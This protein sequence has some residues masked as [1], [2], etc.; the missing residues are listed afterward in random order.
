[1]EGAI[2]SKKLFGGAFNMSPSSSIIIAIVSSTCIDVA[3]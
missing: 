1:M 2:R 3:S